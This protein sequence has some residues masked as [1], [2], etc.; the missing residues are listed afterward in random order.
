MACALRDPG[1]GT[2]DLGPWTQA[3]GPRPGDPGPLTQALAPRPADQSRCI[4]VP[5]PWMTGFVG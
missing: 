4:P 5:K 2:W 3:R 1:P